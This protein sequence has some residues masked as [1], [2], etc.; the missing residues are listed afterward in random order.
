MGNFVA[1]RRVE[2]QVTRERSPVAKGNERI[3]QPAFWL[4]LLVAETVWVG[5][6][7][8]LFVLVL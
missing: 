8:Y 2:A 3:Q 5:G 7:V 1:G 4:L 6:L